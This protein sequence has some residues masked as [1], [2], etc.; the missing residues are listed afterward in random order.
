VLR[1]PG[2]PADRTLEQKLGRCRRWPVEIRRGSSKAGHRHSPGP[3]VSCPAFRWASASA[4]DPPQNDGHGGLG[5]AGHCPNPIVSLCPSHASLTR[6]RRGDTP[7][8]PTSTSSSSTHSP[9]TL[10][11]LYHHLTSQSSQAAHPPTP[12]SARMAVWVK[13]S[14]RHLSC[15]EPNLS[16][17]FCTNQT[18]MGLFFIHP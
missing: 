11:V 16:L 13:L 2:Q 18:N 14:T 4:S 9:L 1:T 12:G 3:S 15:R 17:L 5:K 6:L 10:A 8:P 7:P